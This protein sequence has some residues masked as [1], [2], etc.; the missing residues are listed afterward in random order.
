LVVVEVAAAVML[1]V[2]CGL[3]LRSLWKMQ[4]VDPGFRSAG[5]TTFQ[6]Y[7][8]Q[9]SYPGPETQVA[10][11][12]DLLG[13]LESIPGVERAAGMSGLP[14]RR[15]INANDMEFES[16]APTEDGPPHNVDYWNF[17]AGD[18]FETMG[19]PIVEGR[20]FDPSDDGGSTPVTVI[21]ETM[22]KVFWPDQNP[23]GQRIRPPSDRVPWITIVGIAK[24][25]KQGGLEE[26]TGT[27]CY[28][29]YPQTG[30]LGFA[31]RAMNVVMRSTLPPSSVAESAREA[32][33]SRDTSLPL[34]NLRQM[35][36][37]LSDSLSRPHFVT[38]LL[39]VFALVAL[40]LAAIGTYG[41]LSYAVA[42]R[43]SEIGIRMA[44][45]AGAGRVLKLVLAQGLTLA[46]LGAGL[47]LMF[48]LA[49]SRYLSTM[50][51]GVSTTDLA[52]FVTVPVVLLAVALVACLV[53]AYRAMRIEPVV[54][55][56]YE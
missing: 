36:E 49:L 42:E 23:I 53:P 50:L 32:V 37:V 41:V 1:V 55:L 16:L 8:P 22:A 20:G 47:G 17:V 52:T 38:L 33:W 44:L 2:C 39:V 34:A 7:L 21:N 45:G 54:A 13:R 29:Y 9:T 11:F 3:V 15:R 10:F 19:I 24:D 4:S 48:A 18:Y 27:E 31:P 56:R 12:R 46:L 5:L 40:S 28:F 43:T 25:V 14:P 35:D 6:L 30:A 51:Y 26:E